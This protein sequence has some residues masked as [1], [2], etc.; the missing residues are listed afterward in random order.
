MAIHF[1]DLKQYPTKLL[2]KEAQIVAD[3]LHAT[4]KSWKGQTLI[5][6]PFE[7]LLYLVIVFQLSQRKKLSESYTL[8]CNNKGRKLET[9]RLDKM[10]AMILNKQ[11]IEQCR[12]HKGK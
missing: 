10:I 9:H 3:S 12:S 2:H 6:L 7:P 5:T 8:T 11:A 1:I 4:H